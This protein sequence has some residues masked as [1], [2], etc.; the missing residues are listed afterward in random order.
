MWLAKKGRKEEADEIVHRVFG[1]DVELE[2]EEEQP[3]TSLRMLL[4]SGYMK[5]MVFMGV[6]I[7]CQVVPMY[8]IYTFGPDIMTAFGL[9]EGQESIL[10]ESA[11]SLFFLIGSIP[12]MFW[13]NSMGRRKLLL[14][15]L[16]VLQRRPGHSAVAL[17]QRAVPDRGSRFGCGHRH[18]LLAHWYYCV[19]VRHAA[20][21]G[22]VRCWPHDARGGGACGHL[23]GYV[24]VH[25]SRDQG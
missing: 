10:G 5:R 4:H 18:W 9:G 2:D 25:C 14:I 15:S 8:A 17:S 13:L 6:F 3:K 12:A 24:V 11:V 22:C 16:C 23:P 20:V 21:L 7:L 1:E 19:D